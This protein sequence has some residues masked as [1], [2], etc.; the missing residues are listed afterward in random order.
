MTEIESSEKDSAP[1]RNMNVSH[2]RLPLAHIVQAEEPSTRGL[3]IAYGDNVKGQNYNTIIF[4]YICNKVGIVYL[5]SK[6]PYRGQDVEIVDSFCYF[7][8]V[9]DFTGRSRPDILRRLGI[10]VHKMGHMVHEQHKDDLKT[11]T[12][13]ELKHNDNLQ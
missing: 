1:A 8:N 11:G 12:P 3:N 7:D 13:S 6:N 4:I 2:I 10:A 5:N 9:H